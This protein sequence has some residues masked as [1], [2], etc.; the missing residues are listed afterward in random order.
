M[1]KITNVIASTLLIV[2]IFAFPVFADCGEMG[3]GSKCLVQTVPTTTT[4]KTDTKD[5]FDFDR[6][7]AS[8]FRGFFG[9]IF[10]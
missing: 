10:G 1:K 8:F 6:E 4:P 9:R 2:T 3:S 7:I 5:F